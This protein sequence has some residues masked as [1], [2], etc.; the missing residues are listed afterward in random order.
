MSK[1]RTK[2]KAEELRPL[3]RAK[4]FGTRPDCQAVRRGLRSALCLVRTEAGLGA[5]LLLE[6]FC[7]R[8]YN[9]KKTRCT[10]WEAPADLFVAAFVLGVENGRFSRG[11]RSFG[12][13]VET[14]GSGLVDPGRDALGRRSPPFPRSVLCSLVRAPSARHP[15]LPGAQV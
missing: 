4:G 12:L 1:P 5:D 9:Q 6:P 11:L 7:G 14:G 10:I 2:G 15:G 8:R 3:A 13:T